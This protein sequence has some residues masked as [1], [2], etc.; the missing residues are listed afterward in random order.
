MNIEHA[1]LCNF[2]SFQLRLFHILLSRTRFR[3]YNCQVSI[4]FYSNHPYVPVRRISYTS[5]KRMNIM[6][7]HVYV[8]SHLLFF[9]GK[10]GGAGFRCVVT[11]TGEL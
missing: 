4:L 8:I 3:S 10:R 1:C 7:M 9:M 5:Y 11:L 6:L 2:N